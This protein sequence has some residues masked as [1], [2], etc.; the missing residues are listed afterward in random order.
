M[1]HVLLFVHWVG[2]VLWMG[3]GFAVLIL[4]LAQRREP[5]D[6]LGTL[7]RLQGRLHRSMLLPGALLTVL[8]GL[9]LT[10]RLYGG[11]VS[12]AGFPVP[13]MVMQLTGVIA[14]GIVLGVSLPT[15]ARLDRLDPAGEHAALFRALQQRA[16]LAGSLNG[17]LA[18][19]ALV[20]GV[21][22]R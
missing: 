17:A 16:T 13:L 18:L 21:L 8:S 9:V 20:A 1:R 6:G 11:A 2:I 7:T 3:G 15:I 22:L 4:G 12:S 10:L 14:A 19:T 5:P